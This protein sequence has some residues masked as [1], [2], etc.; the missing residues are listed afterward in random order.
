MKCFFMIAVC[1]VVLFVPFRQSDA[2]AEETTKV[3]IVTGGHGYDE[4]AFE[5]MFRSYPSLACTFVALQDDSE[6]FEDI[7]DWPYDAIVL[8]N[9]T[10][11][12]SEKRREN[13]ILLLE[14]GVGVVVM[15]HAMAAFTGWPEY[16]KISGVTY[17]LEDREE[18]GVLYPRTQWKIG[19]D[20]PL[21]V[22][23]PN[24]PVMEGVQDFTVHDETYK[25]YR[26][27]PGNHLLLSCSEA[28]SQQ[29]VAW[30]RTYANARVC[31]IQPGHGPSVF[32]DANYRR[33]VMQAIEWVARRG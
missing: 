22:E 13:F 25:G 28:R 17:W 15:H 16:R 14:Q 12:I 4:A 32:E 10:Q 2:L 21:H 24:H 29:E 31:T 9:M 20:M 6:V 27:E 30:T 23:D 5:G 33:M 7:S 19:V 8:Y 11:N 3:L 26:L 1:T 18:E